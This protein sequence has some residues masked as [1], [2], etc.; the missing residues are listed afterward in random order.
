MLALHLTPG[1][2]LLPT[3]EKYKELS[4]SNPAADSFQ[5]ALLHLL[6]DRGWSNSLED[7]ARSIAAPKDDNSD[8]INTVN[9]LLCKFLEILAWSGDYKLK[10][11]AHRHELKFTMSVEEGGCVHKMRAVVKHQCY[12]VSLLVKKGSDVAVTAEQLREGIDGLL[13][14]PFVEE[15]CG[16]CDTR[17]QRTLSLSIQHGC[18]PDFITVLCDVPICFRGDNFTIPFSNSRYRLMAVVHW[19]IQARKSAVSREKEDGWWWHGVD[20]G[21]AQSFKYSPSQVQAW[22]HLQDACVLMMVRVDDDQT[23][24]TDPEEDGIEQAIE[25]REELRG[26]AADEHSLDLGDQSVEVNGAV[27]LRKEKQKFNEGGELDHLTLTSSWAG[28]QFQQ[29][30]ESAQVLSRAEN[31]VN[32]VNTG[33]GD[34]EIFNPPSTSTQRDSRHVESSDKKKG[35]ENECSGAAYKRPRTSTAEEADNERGAQVVTNKILLLSNVYW[36]FFSGLFQWDSSF[37]TAEQPT[38]SS[39]PLW[40]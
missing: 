1:R 29:D 8:V 24:N 32:M 5:E 12:Q 18:D 22:R 21:Q 13:K 33:L 35:S 40:L 20:V 6:Q 26:A 30:K 37:S 19:D 31:N 36:V 4:S 10:D 9:K 14:C 34:G 3:L 16:R 27:L 2:R 38:I 25:M 17:V 15:P 23:H 7:L 39:V 28:T 11:M